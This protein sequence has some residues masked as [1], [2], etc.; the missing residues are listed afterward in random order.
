[1]Q[2]SEIREIHNLYQR[3]RAEDPSREFLPLHFGEPDMG[4]PDFIIEAACDALHSGAVFYENN[5]GRPD[6]REELAKFHDLTPE[7]FVVTCGG[8]QAIALSMLGL[9]SPGDSVI[10]IT[11]NWPNFTEAAKLAGAQ[12]HE[13]ALHFD[14]QQ[15]VF[16]LD[17]VHLHQAIVAASNLRM[18][19]VNSPS[20]PTGWVITQ[21]QQ[22]QLFDLCE[23]HD[24]ILVSDEIYD[25]I[26]FTDSSFPSAQKLT[27][28]MDRLII[29]NGFSKTYCM[30]GWRLGYL[31][32]QPAR[33]A[34]MAQMQEFLV[35]HAPSMAQV[36]AIT[37][38]R[39]GEPFITQSMQRYRMLREL[40]TTKLAQL[41]GA[42][43]A[44]SQGSFYTFFQLPQAAD[45]FLFC[46]QL[47]ESTGVALAPGSAFGA[48]GEGWLRLCFANQLHLL[49]EAIDQVRSH[50]C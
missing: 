16:E 20:N 41:P 45:S 30:T 48:G 11:P 3:L 31:I 6:L 8:M 13:V 33:A 23:E 47:L 18:I 43:V 25:R 9:L 15:H 24:L 44:Q 46:K 28:S 21:A 10:N 2:P 17:F 29:I 1:M 37:A 50:V 36:A 14:A 7:H 12:V 5:A 39:D 35:S 34:K 22:Q 26:V 4:T 19:I 40:V 49:E 42:V 32:T 27:N 38:L